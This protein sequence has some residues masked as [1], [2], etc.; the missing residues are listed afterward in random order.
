MRFEHTVTTI[1]WI[2]SDSL[3]G[4]LGITE[5]VR[6]AHP[7]PPPPDLIGNPADA[8]LEAL[9]AEDRYR[10]SNQL[11]AWVDVDDSGRITAAGY[12]GAGRI[13]ST[14][15]NLGVGDVT[16]PA[17]AYELLQLEPEVGDGWVRFRQT[18]GG[19]TAFPLPRPVKHPPFVQYRAPTVWTTLEM[20]IHADGAHAA[21][22]VGASAFP[23][24][25]VFDGAG[26]LVAKSGLTDLKGWL[27]G[28]FGKHTPWGDEDSPA[29]VT[30]VESALE[31]ELSRHIMRGGARPEIRRLKQSDLLTRQGDAATELFLLLDGVVVVDVDGAPVAELGPGVV[32]GERAVLEGGLRTSTLRCATPCRVAVARAD[33][34]DIRALTELAASHRREETLAT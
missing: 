31:R 32:M 4:L 23:R 13:G 11:R 24:H 28:S 29:L 21:E 5:R 6:I 26:C 10:F 33:Q 12:S 14:T 22:L 18:F 3:K 16:A 9:C 30:A 17:V 15:V 1:S 34:M 19:R 25:W 7:D 27:D 2:P 8:T 20:T